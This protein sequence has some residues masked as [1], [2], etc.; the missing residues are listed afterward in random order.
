MNKWTI[1]ILTSAALL[2]VVG[3]V[4]DW[5]QQDPIPST[6]VYPAVTAVGSY[7]FGEGYDLSGEGDVYIGSVGADASA[8]IVVDDSIS[9]VLCIKESYVEIDNPLTS[10]TLS[11]GAGVTFWIKQ[12]ELDSSA[13]L[14]EFTT[15]NKSLNGLELTADGVLT[16]NGTAYGTANA[17]MLAPEDEWHYVAFTLKSDG[18]SVSVDGEVA[19]EYE[20]D[21]TLFEEMI[22]YVGSASTLCMLYNSAETYL[23][24][25]TIYK[26]EIT[27][28]Q[29]ARPSMSSDGESFIVIG[30]TD[31]SATWWS[32][33]SGIH[34]ILDGE[35]FHAGFYNYT[36]GVNNWDN[37]LLVLHDGSSG[38]ESNNVEYV[39]LR[40][41]A[42]G[43]GTTYSSDNLSSDYDWDTFTTYMNG[44]YVDLTVTLSSGVAYITAI[45]EGSDGNTYTMTCS[46]EIPATYCCLFLTVEAAYLKIKTEEYYIDSPMSISTTQVGDSDCSATWWS[47]FSDYFTLEAESGLHLEFTNYTS[48]ANNWDNWLIVFTNDLARDESGYSE[49]VVLR[50]DA[51]GWGTYYTGT[52]TTDWGENDWASWLA[53]HNGAKVAVD[54]THHGTT[55]EMVAVT[56]GT[57]GTVYTY[58]YTVDCGESDAVGVFFTTELGYLVF[59]AS[60]CYS[61]TYLE[62]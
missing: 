28:K 53:Q 10:A 50:A 33:F 5:G 51:Y 4:E 35:T 40:A 57:S 32:T 2:G 20:G 58:T 1:G 26:N 22:S 59:D 36:D 27:S 38:N 37:W 8:A 23:S 45:T 49:Y 25:L 42:Y 47:V 7:A 15:T 34:K 62:D 41:D 31:C 46:V 19:V 60:S 3:C 12:T 55:L 52:M 48:A 14:F 44:A 24:Q 11:N 9:Y 6:D 39:V 21:E 56:T 18:Y 29:T 16:Y 30:S 17:E 43:W 13:S 61:R 54:L